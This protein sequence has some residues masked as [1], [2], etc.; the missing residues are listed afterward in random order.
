M[1]HPKTYLWSQDPIRLREWRVEDQADFL[2][3][4]LDPRTHRFLRWAQ[5]G[6][7]QA[8]LHFEEV[9]AA[10]TETPRSRYFLAVE[11]SAGIVIGDAGFT[12]VRP[13][14]AEIGYFLRSCSWG[15]GWGRAS[16][17]AVVDLATSLGAV[18][19]EAG[20]DAANHASARVLE[21]CGFTEVEALPG[22]RRF[23]RVPLGED[24][25]IP[26]RAGAEVEPLD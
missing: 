2:A 22:R 19:I 16:A 3:W 11:N 6:E 10:Q 7:P 9:L 13:R 26:A 21:R 24:A 23:F 15:R 20:C 14:V 12:W 17:Q 5:G 25:S 8:R 18:R 1:N 4:F